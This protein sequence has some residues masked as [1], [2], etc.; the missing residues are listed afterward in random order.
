MIRISIKNIKGYGNPPVTLNLNLNP[1]KLNIIFA[2]NGSGKTSLATA[3][4][5]LEPNKLMVKE[6]DKFHKDSALKSELIVTFEDKVY[7]ADETQNQIKQIINPYVINCRTTVTTTHKNVGGRYSIASGYMDIEKIV[8]IDK[9]P[10]K[11]NIKYSIRKFQKDF[12]KNGKI[13]KN[14]EQIFFD[15]NFLLEI[16]KL[17]YELNLF[18]KAQK[19]KKLIEEIIKEVQKLNGTGK[20]IIIQ[21]DDN[22]FEDLENEEIYKNIIT[23]LE[24]YCEGFSRW[25]KIDF[26]LQ[27]I[28]FW[29][30]NKLEIKKFNKY[31]EYTKLKDRFITNLKILNFTWKDIYAV[32][33][34]NQLVV[35]FPH[36]DEISNGQR[37]ILTF[38]IELI[39]FQSLIENGKRNFLIIDE[40]FDYLDDAN[41]ITAQYYIS[42]ILELKKED[43]YLCILTHLNPFT[44]RN[45]IFNDKKINF[46]Y[47]N[48]SI[49]HATESMKAFI[50]F[51]GK[52]R[53][54]K[55]E[56]EEDGELLYKDLSNY[57]LHYNP[58]FKDFKERMKSFRRPDHLKVNF[59]KTDFFLD[60]LI[61]EVN[62]YFG[63]EEEY[64]PYAVAI[65]LRRRV[66][67][68]IYEKL[69]NH[70]LQE[71]YLNDN[72]YKLTN[73]KFEF[74]ANNGVEVPDIFL[75]VNAIHN[76]SAHLEQKKNSEE[77]KE[78]AMTYKLQNKTIKEIIKKIFGWDGVPLTKDI[79]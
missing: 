21:I 45:Y 12:G 44:F 60:F 47:L 40:V 24:V 41:I 37:D 65:A 64:D 22:W 10:P 32:E 9:I 49:P 52:I 6:E 13:L 15:P 34:N 31:Y 74:A 62:K 16:E 75:I 3:F 8:A 17:S 26:F 46:I 73:E 35:K 56:N 69:P 50:G 43:I 57:L 71:I 11:G 48:Q 72:R 79:I 67:R 25:E 78:K 66:E 30:E 33:E 39:K 29:D 20:E 68:I 36:A 27:L 55:G 54:E 19:R 1:K 70:D 76:E 7:K 61:E 59:G 2:P 38:S 18:S 77:Y 5:S 14:L 53:G 23:P 58:E 63:D 4:K 42:K 28:K 51:R